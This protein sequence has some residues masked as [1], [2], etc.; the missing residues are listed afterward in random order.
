MYKSALHLHVL[1]AQKVPCTQKISNSSLNWFIES[2]GFL[3]TT[4][5][6]LLYGMLKKNDLLKLNEGLQINNIE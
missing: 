3:Y 1:S 4:F 5:L 6:H 2:P